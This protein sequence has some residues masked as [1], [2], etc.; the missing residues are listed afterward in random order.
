MRLGR[1]TNRAQEFLKSRG[2]V[3]PGEGA[4]QIREKVR[5]LLGEMQ[6]ALKPGKFFTTGGSRAAVRRRLPLNLGFWS[7]I[8]LPSG[9]VTCGVRARSHGVRRFS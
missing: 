9:A 6:T 4:N 5:Y 1:A 8:L 3:P 2:R 7:D